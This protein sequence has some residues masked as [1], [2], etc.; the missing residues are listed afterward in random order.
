MKPWAGLGFCG[1]LDGGVRLYSF[2]MTH[3][4]GGNT[5]WQVQMGDLL[6]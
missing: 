3:E 4:S 5:V 1:A 6:T 2:L